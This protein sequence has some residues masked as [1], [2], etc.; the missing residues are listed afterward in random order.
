MDLRSSKLEALRF[1]PQKHTKWEKICFS[2]SY[3]DVKKCCYSKK[4]L[5]QPFQNFYC[6]LQKLGC[7]LFWWLLLAMYK[8]GVHRPTLTRDGPFM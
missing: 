4:G 7:R 2:K 8:V 1:Y 5:A 3:F 6:F